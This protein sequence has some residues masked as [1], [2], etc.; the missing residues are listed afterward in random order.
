MDGVLSRNDL[1]DDE[2]AK[3]YFQ[4]QNRYLT[5]K[6]QLNT[7]TLPK[8]IISGVPDLTSSTQDSLTAT[9]A[10]STPLNPFNVTPELTQAAVSQKPE[11]E[12]LTPPPSLNAALMTPP[13]TVKTPSQQ[14]PKGKRRWIQFLNYLDDH[15]VH[16]KQVRKRSRRKKFKPYKYSVGEEDED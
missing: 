10:V 9:T 8:E 5:F 2:K 7:K 11:K 12:R 15:N 1:R 4:L 14:G 13:L 6:E 16:G 3:R